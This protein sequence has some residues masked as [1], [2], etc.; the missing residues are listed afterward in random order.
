MENKKQL[1]FVMAE[2]NR[3][4]AER[5]LI[6]LLEMLDRSRYDIDVLVFNAS[7]RLMPQIPKEVRILKADRRLCCV[8]TSSKKELLKNF[9]LRAVVARLIYSF[10]KDKNKIQYVQSQEKWK[11]V[12]QP[13]LKTLKK[14]YDVAIAYM[15]S[16]PSYYVI[17]KVCAKRKI[18]WVHNDYS[19]LIQGK[20]FDY[21]YFDRADLIATVSQQCVCELKK[22]FPDMADKFTCIY[23][24]NPENKI[25]Q[26]ADAFYP[27]EYKDEEKLKLVSIGRLNRQKGFDFAVDAAGILKKNGIPFDWFIIGVGELKSTLCQ[28]IESVG[29]ENEVHLLGERE[30]PYPYIKNADIVVQ[31]SRFEG[32]SIVLD[33]AKILHKPI[34]T[35]DYVSVRDQIEDGN[36]GMIIPMD[37]R[38]IAETIKRVYENPDITKGLIENLENLPD[39]SESELQ[40]YNSCFGG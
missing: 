19:K 16:L 37:P 23:N 33:E 32:K 11:Y 13:V 7:G 28:Q 40:K 21:K 4:G 9:S 3:G 2:M 38:V 39:E 29:V 24:L 17:D 15:H 22:A 12:Y 18:L 14:E 1:L 30:N 8:S 35:T 34:I 6:N 25:R 31:T 27:D 10:K 36:T 5:S 26:K 20:E